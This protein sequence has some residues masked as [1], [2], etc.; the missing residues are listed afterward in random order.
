[1]T[2]QRVC[3]NMIVKN[4]SEVIRRALDSV[5]DHVTD[6]VILDGS[7]DNRTQNEILAWGAITNTRGRVIRDNP[8]VP[9]D[10]AEARNKA[11]YQARKYLQDP[12]AYLLFLDADDELVWEP[13]G[14]GVARFT[15]DA[16]DLEHRYNQFRYHRIGLLRVGCEAEW[17]SPYHEYLSLPERATREFL[18]CAWIKYNHDGVRSKDPAVHLGPA[19]GLAKYATRHPDDTRSCFYAAQEFIAAGHVFKAL[20]WYKERIKRGRA[21]QGYQDEVLVSWY[22][23]GL[24]ETQVGA[25]LTAFQMAIQCQP[26]RLE[27]YWGAAHLCFT[28][29]WLTLARMYASAGVGMLGDTRSQEGL[30]V[31][32]SARKGLCDLYKELVGIDPEGA[33]SG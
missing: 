6:F 25:A 31:D 10:F 21:G 2:K 26:W 20:D 24:N 12:D 4:E 5:R 3:L 13:D 9:F 33:K 7:P 17:C 16:Y 29:G 32:T 30:F 23:I 11:L 28:R 14:R 15:A 8:P 1:M 27:P 19:E 22:Q 18:P